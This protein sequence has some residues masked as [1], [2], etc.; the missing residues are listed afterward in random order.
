MPKCKQSVANKG[1]LTRKK[2]IDE[3]VARMNSF[4]IYKPVIRQFR[5]QGLVNVSEAPCGACFWAKDN[6]SLIAKIAQFEAEN[7]ALVFHVIHTPTSIGDFYDF[8]YVSR[9]EEEWED[10]QEMFVTGS[11]YSYC[12]VADGEEMSEIGE[13]GFSLTNAGGLCRTY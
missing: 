9:H 12:W 6:P 3:A 8:L 1:I 13:I 2:Q 4:K 10:D 5:D 11:C 7:G